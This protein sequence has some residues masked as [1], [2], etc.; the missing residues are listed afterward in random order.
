MEM[1]AAK[2]DNQTRTA[3]TPQQVWP[4]LTI[5]QQETVRQTLV[6][7]CQQLVSQWEKEAKNEPKSDE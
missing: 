7:I 3:T 5:S 4:R 2:T 1:A 6:R